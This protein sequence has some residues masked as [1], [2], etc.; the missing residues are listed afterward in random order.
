MLI[1][2]RDTPHRVPRGS[3]FLGAQASRLLRQRPRWP[4]SQGTRDQ[5]RPA[6]AVVYLAESHN[7][8]C[9]MHT[10]PGPTLIPSCTAFFGLLSGINC[11]W[12]ATHSHICSPN[13]HDSLPIQIEGRDR[14]SV[15]SSETHNL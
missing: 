5:S 14:G 8:H 11:R 10:S 7:E 9:C 2:Q 4:R 12:V 3:F 1:L 15:N 6:T 13:V